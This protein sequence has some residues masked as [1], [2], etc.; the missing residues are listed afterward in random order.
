MIEKKG[1][2]K[3]K[4]CGPRREGNSDECERGE[5]SSGESRGSKVCAGSRGG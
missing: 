4:R 5:V 3:A 1:K 2:L